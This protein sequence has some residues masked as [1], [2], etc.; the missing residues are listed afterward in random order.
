MRRREGHR[1][2]PADY[3]PAIIYPVAATTTA[4]LERSD[5]LAFL[6]STLAKTVFEKIRLQVPGKPL[7]L[8]VSI[9]PT[10]FVMSLLAQSVDTKSRS[11]C[12]E[13]GVKPTRFAHLEVFSS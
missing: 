4:K 11:E 10:A 9:H 3:H 2:L 5:Y 7:N 8:S 1:H 12:P 13:S 6:R